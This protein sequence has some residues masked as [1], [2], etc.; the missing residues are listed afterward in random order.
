[1]P[2]PVLPNVRTLVN[3][4]ATQ[5]IQLER[6]GDKAQNQFGG[7]EPGPISVFTVEPV[8]VHNAN[9]R[10]L[11]Q[12]PEADRTTEIVKFIARESSFPAGQQSGFRVADDG[13]QSDVAIYRGRRFRI[14]GVRDFVE[15]GDVWIALGALEDRQARP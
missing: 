12:V 10:D 6:Q 15:Q 7:W 11:Q 2:I 1:M 5:P 4:L 14:V 3:T 8:S 9:A 13:Y